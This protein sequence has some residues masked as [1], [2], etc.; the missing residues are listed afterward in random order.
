MAMPL[1]QPIKPPPEAIFCHSFPLAASNNATSSC[2]F[3][4]EG[5]S[6]TNV[7]ICDVRLLPPQNLYTIL[8]WYI[9]HQSYFFGLIFNNACS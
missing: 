6:R 7:E 2:L 9:S 1:L 5:L 3:W 8:E 4:F